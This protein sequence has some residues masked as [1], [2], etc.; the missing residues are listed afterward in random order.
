[1]STCRSCGAEIAWAITR[2]TEKPM[3]LDA[4][5]VTDG[6]VAVSRDGAGNLMARVLAA[7]EGARSDEKL[8]RSHFATCPQA[9]S[10]RTRR[11]AKASS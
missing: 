3:P 4:L 2:G 8:G 6:N 10:W 1:M 11:D 9:D 5:P 7:G